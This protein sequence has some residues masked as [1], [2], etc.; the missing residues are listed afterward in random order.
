FLGQVLDR[1]T[2]HYT[3]LFLL[4]IAIYGTLSVKLDSK[5]IWVFT[6]V[7]L[8]SWF[9]TETA[10][11]SNWGFKFWG[12]N[13]P[14]RFTLI[15]LLLTTFALC[16]QDK[17]KPLHAFGSTSYIVGLLCTMIALWCLSIF[18]NYSD[19]DASTQ[20][21]QYHIL[22]WGILAVVLSLG[23]ALYGMKTKDHA[24]R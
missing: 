16:G 14:L 24:S 17:I 20:V 4:S 10:Y 23:L 8:G 1:T 11:H 13:Y 6:L 15:V 12:M 5:L 19:F 3:L 7:A 22:C 9:A 2:N 18:G 21:R